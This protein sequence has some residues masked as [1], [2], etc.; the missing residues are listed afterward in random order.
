MRDE[1]GTVGPS[2]RY[3]PHVLGPGRA[4]LALLA[5][6]AAVVVAIVLALSLRG[7]GP[8]GPPADAQPAIA[9]LTSGTPER[10]ASAVDPAALSA[11]NGLIFPQGSKTA[12]IPNSWQQ[13]S[14][15]ASIEVRVFPPGGQVEV[16]R[17]YLL[18][19]GSRWQIEF[20][21]RVA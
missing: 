11:V 18:H 14:Q 8:S 10:I 2:P 17:F 20:S 12:A 5:A 15:S 4:R 19:L 13:T 16:L 3:R 7:G 21:E 6:V 9:A 1:S